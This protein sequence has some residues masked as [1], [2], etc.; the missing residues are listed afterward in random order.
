MTGLF[1]CLGEERPEVPA[2]ILR[3]LC[4]MPQEYPGDV[5]EQSSCCFAFWAM[6]GGVDGVSSLPHSRRDMGAGAGA[7][8]PVWPDVVFPRSPSQ[9]LLTGMRVSFPSA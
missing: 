8:V 6:A 1:L 2:L 7:W 3:E 5:P 4:V 9:T